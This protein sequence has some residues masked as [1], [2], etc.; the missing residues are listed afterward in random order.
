[1]SQRPPTTTME[2]QFG[3]ITDA[4]INALPWDGMLDIVWAMR[5]FRDSKVNIF[6]ALP[7]GVNQRTILA[8]KRLCTENRPLLGKIING[9]GVTPEDLQPYTHGVI[10]PKTTKLFGAQKAV[11]R[12]VAKKTAQ[13]LQPETLRTTLGSL[14]TASTKEQAIL[15]RYDNPQAQFRTELADAVELIKSGAR[16]NRKA[17]AGPERNP[18]I[19]L[20]SDSVVAGIESLLGTLAK[21]K[22]PKQ[23]PMLKALL[24]A[25]L[26]SVDV[27]RLEPKEKEKHSARRAGKLSWRQRLAVKAAAPDIMAG[28][29]E[30]IRLLSGGK[31]GWQHSKES[32]FTQHVRRN[33]ANGW[34]AIGGE[35][36]QGKI[37][38]VHDALPVWLIGIHNTLPSSRQDPL[39]RVLGRVALWSQTPS[40]R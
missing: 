22:D 14:L 27:S 16:E 25:H 35:F 19:H 23:L 20:T 7:L 26:E 2:Q 39:R 13:Y 31:S 3:P 33:S 17:K 37:D 28:L 1:M 34:A 24:R 36:F 21:G 10:A 6:P 8:A 9:E 12:F 15:E 5:E 30:A 40:K 29:E 38:T 32:L 18:D 11:G 4:E